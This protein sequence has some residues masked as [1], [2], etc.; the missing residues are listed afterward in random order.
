[1]LI[2]SERKKSLLTLGNYLVEYSPGKKGYGE[3]GEILKKAQ[4][5]NEWFTADNL[6]TALRAWGEVLSK[7]NI[8]QWLAGYAFV[9]DRE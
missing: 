9:N 8:D 2:E 7:E 5:A 1:M 3:L 4:A 6:K